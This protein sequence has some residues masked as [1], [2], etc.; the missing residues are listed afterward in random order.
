M[1]LKFIT[2]TDFAKL[3]FDVYDHRIN[4]AHEIDSAINKSYMGLDEHLI[5]FFLYRYRVRDKVEKRIIEFLSSLKYYM[6]YW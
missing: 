6:D 1:K 2:W 5:C 4:N 3:I